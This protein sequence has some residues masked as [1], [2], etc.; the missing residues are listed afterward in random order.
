MT[1]LSWGI[2]RD[3]RVQVPNHVVHRALPHETVFLNVTTSTYHAVDEVGARFFE[4]ILEAPSLEAAT[5]T[6]ASEY[7]QPLDRIETDMVTFCADLLARDL[8]GLESN[9]N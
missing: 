1:D 6:L 2:L 8:I 4:V 3:C 5:V 7:E 9:R